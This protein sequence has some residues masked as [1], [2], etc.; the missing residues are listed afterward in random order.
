MAGQFVALPRY[1]NVSGSIDCTHVAVWV[2][3]KIH[4]CRWSKNRCIKLM[5]KPY[6]RL[7]WDYINIT[8][9]LPLQA[10]GDSGFPLR[11]WLLTAFAN[12][13]VQRNCV[14]M[15]RVQLWPHQTQ[16]PLFISIPSG[17]SLHCFI[18][19][20]TLLGSFVD[21]AKSVSP[22]FSEIMPHTLASLRMDA[23][24]LSS[25]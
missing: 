2:P 5:Y 15:V 23:I 13:R 16:M 25:G 22:I 7:A 20:T 14:T 24:L 4:F 21:P 11:H 12:H 10:A 3:I 17:Q 18:V 8:I 19:F 6:V 1:P 9:D